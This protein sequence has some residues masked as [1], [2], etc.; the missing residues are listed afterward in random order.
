MKRNPRLKWDYMVHQEH[1]FYCLELM[2]MY[3]DGDQNMFTCT[4]RTQATFAQ[5]LSVL[6]ITLCSEMTNSSSWSLNPC[7]YMFV[8]NQP[9]IQWRLTTHCLFV[10]VSLQPVRWGEQNNI[11]ACPGL[12]SSPW[13]L[14]P[15]PPLLSLCYSLPLCLGN[16]WRLNSKSEFWNWEI[17]SI[18]W[19]QLSQ[20]ITV[21]I[22]SHDLW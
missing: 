10:Y 6:H 18:N 13:W 9:V 1:L 2:M 16:L 20:S 14:S 22:C 4:I 7:V 11:Q 8:W 17:T 21:P 12:S 5:F 19:L 3:A 15:P